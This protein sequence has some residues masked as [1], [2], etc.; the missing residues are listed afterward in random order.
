[1]GPLRAL[2]DRR[3]EMTLLNLALAIP[4]SLVAVTVASFFLLL[5]LPFVLV[6]RGTREKLI[7][8]TNAG[9]S[10]AVLRF[11]LLV[12][13]LSVVGRDNLPEYGSP[14]LVVS[15]HRG[16][17][18]VLTLIWAAR[19][20]GISKK[21]VLYFPAMGL[22]GYLGGAVFFDRD[23]P[24]DRLRAKD[25]ALFLLRRG[26]P[27]HVYPEGRRTRDGRL[28]TDVQLGMLIAAS[29]AGIP[30]VPA[31]VWGTDD[32][33]PPSNKGI[34]YFQDITVR[35]GEPLAPSDFEDPAAHAEA[36][37]AQVGAMVREFEEGS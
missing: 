29:E 18:D 27:L 21:L 5:A 36:A 33:I 1:M 4:T 10:W 13:G 3:G 26:V 25:D 16:F 9:A 15:N 17:C 22:L 23:D 24:A 2:V 32:V 6:P 35:F 20:E 30:L 37:W 14:Y 28:G 7:W 31:A 34:R 8:W 19:A 11:A 12:K